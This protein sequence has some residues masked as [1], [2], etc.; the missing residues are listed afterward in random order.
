MNDANAKF[1]YGEVGAVF[2]LKIT[3]FLRFNQCA[4]LE[5][6][7]KKIL[8]KHAPDDL[9]VDLSEAESLDSTAL[10]LLAQIALQFEK[11]KHKKAQLCC[12]DN[13]LKK[14]LLSMSLEQLFEFTNN[15]PVN[16]S[17]PELSIKADSDSAQT[18]RVLHAHETLMDLSEKNSKEFKSVVEMLQESLRR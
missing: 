4:A 7:L 1:Y 2:V 9:L 5:Y 6:F 3:G 18:Q 10:G 17:L 8:I 14:I 13:D 11:M 15:A 16:T 12:R